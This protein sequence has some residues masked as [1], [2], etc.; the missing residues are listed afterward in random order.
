MLRRKRPPINPGAD[1]ANGYSEGARVRRL[2]RRRAFGCAG[3]SR[4]ATNDAW[5]FLL[6]DN[7]RP[8]QRRALRFL[9]RGIQHEIRQIR[10]GHLSRHIEQLSRFW[11]D[12]HLDPACGHPG[13]FSPGEIADVWLLPASE[14][15]PRPLPNIPE[16][17][18]AAI[19]MGAVCACH[20]EGIEWDLTVGSTHSRVP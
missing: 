8:I 10:P 17:N 16:C 1:T 13:S 7:D 15:L 2:L 20:P 14:L 6:I 19:N 11:F 3:A 5:A 12:S 4:S 9:P 18:A